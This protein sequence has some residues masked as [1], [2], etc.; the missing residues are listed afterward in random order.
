MAK[1]VFGN[2]AV[3][4]EGNPEILWTPEP[5]VD[6]QPIAWPR[7]IVLSGT[8]KCLHAQTAIDVESGSG[9]VMRCSWCGEK[10]A[11]L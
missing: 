2:G 6:T 11:T 1:I 4:F 8:F 9:I 5:K 10:I 3:E 7:T